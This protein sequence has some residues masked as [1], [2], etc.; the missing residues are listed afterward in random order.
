MI[1]IIKGWY[2]IHIISGWYHFSKKIIGVI[3]YEWKKW[4]MHDM[5]NIVVSFT[6]IL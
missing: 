4:R 1:I 5:N 2:I 6:L 3:H